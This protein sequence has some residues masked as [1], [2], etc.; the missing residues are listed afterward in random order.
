MDPDLELDL[1][2]DRDVQ[3]SLRQR[4]LNLDRALRRFQRAAEFHQ[5][6]VADSLDFGAVKHRKNSAQQTAMLF[7]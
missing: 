2:V 3:I 4:A 5:E 7:Q 1:A 6:R